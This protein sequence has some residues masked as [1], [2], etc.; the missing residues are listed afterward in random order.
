MEQ[1]TNKH[2]RFH[3]F[4]YK[5]SLFYKYPVLDCEVY[6]ELKELR[7]WVKWIPVVAAAIALLR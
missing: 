6:K 2:F 7:P 5:K 4:R 1:V 3:T